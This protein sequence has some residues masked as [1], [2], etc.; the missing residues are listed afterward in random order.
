LRP[1]LTRIYGGWNRAK[2]KERRRKRRVRSPRVAFCQDVGQMLRDELEF[3]GLLA[4]KDCVL[5]A[6]NKYRAM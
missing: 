2:K 1:L 6:K 5:A 4:A 3:A